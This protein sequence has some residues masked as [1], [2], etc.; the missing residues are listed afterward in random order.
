MK[1][2][3]LYLFNAAVIIAVVFV[4]TALANED[5]NI[6]FLNAFGWEV[7]EGYIEK[8]DITIPEEFDAVYNGYNE[9]Q[10]QA[11]FDLERYKGR[12]AV[13]YT[14]IVKNYPDDVKNEV[15][16]NVICVKGEPVGGDVMTVNLD[17]C[18]NPLNFLDTGIA[19]QP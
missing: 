17:G 15:R 12:K 5:R 13:R 4:C 3:I 2:M 1:K 8:A 11:G 7:E 6:E 14:Y 18:M 19:K 10:K 16:A 9:I